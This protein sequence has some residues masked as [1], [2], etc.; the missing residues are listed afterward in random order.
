MFLKKWL[1]DERRHTSP[2]EKRYVGLTGFTLIELLVVIAIISILAAMLLPALQQAREKAR[3]ITCTNNLKQ[4]FLVFTLYMNDYDGWF[5]GEDSWPS[6]IS[7]YRWLG[8]N[9]GGPRYINV[10]S[11]SGWLGSEIEGRGKGGIVDCPSIHYGDDALDGTVYTNSKDNWM[12]Y[13]VDYFPA[14][15][16]NDTSNPSVWDSFKPY[17]QM[18]VSPSRQIMAMDAGWNGV[19]LHPWSATNWRWSMAR[20]SG[21]CNFLYWDGHVKW[22]LQADITTDRSDPFWNDRD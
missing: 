6:S 11:E 19:L 18:N 20:H 15:D 14:P 7:L 12:D 3:Q 1:Y 13:K 8:G 16:V 9:S 5:P 10:A 21:G 4:Q 22:I 2:T 17:S